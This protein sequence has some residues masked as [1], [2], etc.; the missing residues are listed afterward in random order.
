VA[1]G[2]HALAL[3]GN[4][5]LT[6]WP[7]P[8]MSVLALTFVGLGYGVISGV[9]A[10]GVAAYWRRALYGRVASRLYTA[11]AA[12]AVVL[13]IAAGRLFDLTQGYRAAVLIAGGA[14]L[15]GVIVGFALPHQDNRHS[16]VQ[17]PDRSSSTI[18]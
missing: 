9:T 18:T 7:G 17:L 10:A 4:V 11:W 2:A 5:A 6:L 12:A 16:D 15:L 1:G 3:A 14:N 8:G 13:P